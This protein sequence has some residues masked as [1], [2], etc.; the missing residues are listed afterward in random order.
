MPLAPKPLDASDVRAIGWVFTRDACLDAIRGTLHGTRWIDR[1]QLAGLARQWSAIGK[2]SADSPQVVVADDTLWRAPRVG[3]GVSAALEAFVLKLVE[4]CP[5][6]YS[7]GALRQ[8]RRTSLA[9]SVIGIGGSVLVGQAAP[10]PDTFVANIALV[11][12][13]MGGWSVATTLQLS[14]VCGIVERLVRDTR[15]AGVR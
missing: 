10:G 11:L 13:V 5:E 12:L 2:A 14:R 7:L 8:R 4:A 3:T 6:R 15:T 9:Q 1:Q